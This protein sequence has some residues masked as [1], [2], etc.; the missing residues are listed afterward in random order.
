MNQPWS[1]A[2]I[3]DVEERKKEVFNALVDQLEEMGHV[4]GGVDAPKAE[5]NTV[6]DVWVGVRLERE[7]ES[8]RDRLILV[9][10][11]NTGVIRQKPEPNAGFDLSDFAQN[12]AKLVAQ[13]KAADEEQ[14][15]FRA[16]QKKAAALNEKFKISEGGPVICKATTASSEKVRVIVDLTT[17]PEKA[18]AIL[19]AATE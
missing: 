10:D 3:L 5:I 8:R 9:F 19:R 15:S 2:K 17:S 1:R 12:L 6:D 18:A 7:E 4:L 13:K 16:S 14:E 11:K